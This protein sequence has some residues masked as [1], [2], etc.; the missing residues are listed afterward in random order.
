[1]RPFVDEHRGRFGV[2]PICRAMEVS[3]RSYFAAKV[4]SPSDRAVRDIVHTAEIRAVWEANYRVYG[5]ERVWRALER[6][7]YRIARCT[8]ERLMAADGIHGVVRGKRVFTTIADVGA[9][10]PADLVERRFVATRPNQLWVTDVTYAKTWEGF[11]YVSFILDVFSRMIVG[12]QLA[13]HL[14]TDLVLDALEMAIWRRDLTAGDLIHHSDRGCQYT[15]FRYTQRLADAGIAASVGTVADAYDNAMAEALNGTYK[16]ELVKPTQWHTQIDLE[17]ATVE[18]IGWYNGT[19]LHG[20][21]GH[22]PPAEFEAT[23]YLH[24]PT[25]VLTPSN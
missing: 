9:S 6:A 15:S 23:W 22:V 16:H 12:W 13:D 4:R 1:M 5:A 10:R 21:I 17:L 25:L 11:V 18:W 2:A 3:E 8:V 14:R 19:R 7:D 24:H 20:E